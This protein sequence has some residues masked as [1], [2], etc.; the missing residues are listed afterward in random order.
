MNEPADDTFGK[1]LAKD[2]NS[3]GPNMLRKAESTINNSVKP[4]GKGSK[5]ILR[6]RSSNLNYK[7]PEHKSS[8][9]S[10]FKVKHYLQRGN[11]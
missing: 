8:V 7:S 9:A 1:M 3:L 10:S 5:S 4:L 6:H 2:R 11:S